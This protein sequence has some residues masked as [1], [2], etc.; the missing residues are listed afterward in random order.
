LTTVVFR[1]RIG[2]DFLLGPNQGVIV[3][4]GQNDIK[5]QLMKCHQKRPS[6]KITVI[7][8]SFPIHLQLLCE[9]LKY[10]VLPSFGSP[11]GQI[12][13]SLLKSRS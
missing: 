12:L 2:I 11:A 8:S 4:E 1:E 7:S 10:R 3:H 6:M 13:P 9:E 5:E